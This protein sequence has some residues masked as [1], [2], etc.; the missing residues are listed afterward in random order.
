MHIYIVLL[1]SPYTDQGEEI[2]PLFIPFSEG[3]TSF[4]FV[5][6]G[7]ILPGLLHNSAPIAPLGAWYTHQF[8]GIPLLLMWFS[9]GYKTFAFECQG[10]I[11]TPSNNDV[12]LIQQ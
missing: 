12:I 2:L 6:V 3:L 8:E 11:F 4:I 10:T 5:V 9:K 1:H 7:E